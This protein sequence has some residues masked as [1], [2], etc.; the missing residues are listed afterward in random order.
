MDV[1]FKCCAGLDVHQKDVWACVR[2]LQDNGRVAKEIRKFGTMTA[3][4]LALAAWLK[5]RGVTHTAMESTGVLWK[6]VYNMLE[7]V[8]PEVWLCNARHMRNLPGRKTDVKDCDWIAQ[9]MQ[10]GLL[11]KSFVPPKP[12]RQLRDLTRLRAS[13]EEDKTRLSNRIHKVLEDANI[14]LGA[15]ASDVLGVSGRA[16]LWQLIG[17][18]SDGAKLAGLA[19][20]ALKRKHEQLEQALTGFVSEH[21]RMLLRTLL[22]QLNALEQSIART[23]ALIAGEMK[24]AD[25][26]AAQTA[27]EAPEPEAREKEAPAEKPPLPFLE[28]VKLLSGI[29][30]IKQRNAENI[31][32]EI[33][34]DMRHWI[35]DR[36]FVSWAGVCPGNNISAGKN[37]GGATNKGN[38]WLRRAITQSAWVSARSKK[39]FYGA[40]YRRLAKRRGKQRAIVAVTSSMLKA[41]YHM[42]KKHTAFADLGPEHYEKNPRHLERAARKTLERLGYKVTL[43]PAA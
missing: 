8:I 14:K 17:G 5:E 41:I 28:A 34:T 39:T 16:M 33:G 36:H 40:R 20:G 12:V 25:E 37:L 43:E 1:I 15:V 42:L 27:A 32:A 2:K 23:D 22:E 3:D 4:L 26:A 13:F 19:R 29:L 31:L 7:G 21:H 30:G 9:L 24:Q 11:K 10:C 38:N 35:T 6:P 18:E